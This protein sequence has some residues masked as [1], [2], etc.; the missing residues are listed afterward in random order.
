MNTFSF[1]E[2]APKNIYYLKSLH[3]GFSHS[4]ECMNL[5]SACGFLWTEDFLKEGINIDYSN[6]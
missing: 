5:V 3:D 4:I 6:E 1:L 2:N